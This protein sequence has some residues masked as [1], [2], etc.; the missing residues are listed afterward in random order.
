LRRLVAEAVATAAHRVDPDLLAAQVWLYRCAALVGVAE[1]SQR[2][3]PLV[4]KYNAPARRLIDR[5]DD[6]LRFTHDLR[7]TP[8]NNGSERDIRMVKLRQKVSGG[9]AASPEPSNSAR[10]AA[11]YPLPPRTAA[12]SSKLSSCSPRATLAA[13]MT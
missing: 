4:R 3:N 1:T 11:I 10:F 13:C 9:A 12:I 5:Q 7:V 6:Y 8:D 2:S